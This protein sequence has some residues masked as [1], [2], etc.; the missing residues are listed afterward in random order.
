[1]LLM[2]ANLVN[3]ITHQIELHLTRYQVFCNSYS[4]QFNIAKDLSGMARFL[5]LN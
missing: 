4:S 3:K 1:M 5:K 2:V